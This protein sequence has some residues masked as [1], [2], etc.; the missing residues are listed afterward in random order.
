MNVMML[1][2][3][4]GTR[5]RPHTMYVPKPA[6]SFLNVPLYAYSLYFL[7]E[8]KVKKVVMNT[9]HLPSKLKATVKIFEHGYPIFFSDEDVLLGS[10]GGIGHARAYFQSEGDFILMNGD[11]VIIP[12]KLDQIKKVIEQ[13]KASG[14]IATVLVIEHPD[15]GTKFGGVWVDSENKVLGFGKDKVESAVKGYHYIGVTIFSEK[16]F[17]YI[18]PGESNILYDALTDAIKD[19]NTAQICQFPCHWF[20]TGNE[21]DFKTATH[22]CMDILVQKTSYS[23]YLS[24][25]IKWRSPDTEFV[26]MNNRFILADKKLDFEV[27]VLFGYNVIGEGVTLKKGCRLKNCIIGPRVRIEN[28][29]QLENMMIV[30]DQDVF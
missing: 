27:E 7:N 1:T 26:Q 19:G 16:I 4:E 3:G 13:H 25:V 10:G 15:V 9:F 24:D 17:N 29:D 30:N 28:A 20:E 8:V 12:K 22:K 2:A 5:L 18:R 14:A 6:I 11:E 21:T 23:K